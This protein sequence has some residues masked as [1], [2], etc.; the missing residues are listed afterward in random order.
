MFNDSTLKAIKKL[1]DS[2]GRPLWQL[3]A[4]SSFGQKIAQDT[5]LGYPYNINQSMATMGA[6]SPAVGNISLLFGAFN[7]FIVRDV[8]EMTLLRLTERYAEYGQ[9]GFLAFARCDS[10]YI[11]SNAV[12]YFQ[13]S[14]T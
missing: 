5:I 7:R 13:N 1:K 2:N 3:Y 8:L 10:R 4:E 11:N 14:A 12:K 6:G 9:V